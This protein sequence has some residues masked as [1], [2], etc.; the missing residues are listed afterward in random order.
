[1][2]LQNK[3]F[4]YDDECCSYNNNDNN[5]NINNLGIKQL[6]NKRNY[7]LN[8]DIKIRKKSYPKRKES[9]YVIIF[10]NAFHKEKFINTFKYEIPDTIKTIVKDSNSSLQN[11]KITFIEK[12]NENTKIRKPRTKNIYKV[13]HVKEVQTKFKFFQTDILYPLFISTQKDID[14]NSLVPFIDGN[15]YNTFV[16]VLFTT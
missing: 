4:K 12:C 11:I 13:L 15:Q 3:K 14:L 2:F 9:S 8:V 6:S 16:D 1:M 10:S 7:F 5:N